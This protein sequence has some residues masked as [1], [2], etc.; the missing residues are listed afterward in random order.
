MQS[1]SSIWQFAK[2][3]ISRVPFVGRLSEVSKEDLTQAFY[4]T[5]TTM[6]FTTMPF[7]ILPVLG[8]FIFRP[9]PSFDQAFENGEGLVFAAALLGPLFYV[10]T[11]RYGRWS[12]RRTPDDER[13]NP[14]SVSFPYGIGFVAI[15]AL[16]CV[17]SGFAFALLRKGPIS[18]D[19]YLPGVEVL[20]WVLVGVATITF[21]AVTAYRN[22]LDDLASD[23]AEKVV[24]QQSD[25]ENKFIES[26]LGEKK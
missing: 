17:I 21:F 24:E 6:V 1:L 4:E 12:L 9:R 3:I 26:W 23:N 11:K 19:I 18:S 14:L 22:M 20:S 16:T 15:I 2:A 25:S 5:L 10:L 7:W 13:S 8:L